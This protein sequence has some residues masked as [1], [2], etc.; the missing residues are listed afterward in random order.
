ML[1][2]GWQAMAV[3]CESEDEGEAAEVQD[4]PQPSGTGRLGR[5]KRACPPE[6]G[7]RCRAARPGVHCV[8]EEFT[9]SPRVA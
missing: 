4:A 2:A 9:G 6:A 8:A 7:V 3:P 5:T 1:A